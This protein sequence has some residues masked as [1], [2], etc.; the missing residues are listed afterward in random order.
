MFKGLCRCHCTHWSLMLSRAKVS[1]FGHPTRRKTLRTPR[2]DRWTWKVVSALR[3][4]RKVSFL[5]FLVWCNLSLD[6]SFMPLACR[7]ICEGM[8]AKV[9]IVYTHC[10]KH[11]LEVYI[12]SIIYRFAQIML[13]SSIM[14]HRSHQG[15]SFLPH[16][17]FHFYPGPLAVSESGSETVDRTL[18]ARWS[19]HSICGLWPFERPSEGCQGELAAD[20]IKIGD[21]AVL[22]NLDT[23]R[24][25]V[26]G[27]QFLAKW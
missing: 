27:R 14:Y 19:S 4:C 3:F 24:G 15:T 2:M 25:F 10:G 5:A 13:I 11:H 21:K 26:A 12:D 16:Y 18:L 23:I 20:W 6:V 1:Y 8:R 22:S 9:T 17:S 7:I